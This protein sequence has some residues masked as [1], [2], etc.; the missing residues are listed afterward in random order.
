MGLRREC[1]LGSADRWGLDQTAGLITWLFGDKAANATGSSPRV[2]RESLPILTF[3][4]VRLTYNDG[5][6]RTIT[7]DVTD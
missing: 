5:K 4:P 6:A 3:A 1:G 7:V 2:R